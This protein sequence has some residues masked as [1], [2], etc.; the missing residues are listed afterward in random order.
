M[1][2]LL[3]SID[4]NWSLIEKNF[5]INHARHYESIF[6]LG[7]GYMTVRAIIEE[8]FE[9]DDQA[10]EYVR[11]MD[12]TTLE[13]IPAK[14]SRWGTFI[15]VFQA[16]H[17][18]LR[19]G[20]AN[21]P[22]FLNLIVEVNGEKLDLEQSIVKNHV[23]WLDLKQAVLYRTFLWE[24]INDSQLEFIYRTYMD[25][26][27]KFVSTQ[28]VSIRQLK[29]KSLIRVSGGID[30]NV[31]TNGYD[32]FTQ[33]S[34]GVS[35][36]GAI[37]SDVT[38]N[39]D[40]RVVTASV[41]NVDSPAVR[42]ENRLKRSISCSYD[43]NLEEGEVV[44][45]E[46]ISATTTTTYF[47]EVELLSTAENLINQQLRKSSE[48]RFK[49]HINAWRQKWEKSDIRIKAQD[50][51]NYNSQQAIRAAIYHLLRAKAEDEDRVMLCP[52]GS[53]TE[54]YYGSVFWDMEIFVF[55]FFLYHYPQ[56]ARTVPMFRVRN[57]PAAREIAQQYNY[58]GARYPWQSD[59]YG[60]ETCV[61]W[62]YADHQV[63]ISAD[64][65]LAIWH[66][67]RN[68][69]DKE[70]LFNYGAEVLIETARYWTERVDKIPGRPGYQ[71]L[72][73][74]GPDEYKPLTNNNAYTNRLVQ[75]NLEA[76]A[77]VIEMLIQE[78][79]D[80]FDQLGLKIGLNQHETQK[81]RK[82]AEGIS[83]PI[84]EDR[85]IIWQ[86]DDFDTAY[87]EIDIDALWKDRS[88]LFGFFV[89]QEKRYRSKCM[90]QSDVAVLLGLFSEEFSFEQKANSFDYYEPYNMQDS[91]NS[92]C[93][94]Q[95]LAAAIQRP[96]LAYEAWK[97]SIDLDFG[98]YPRDENGI[99]FANV[100]GMWQEIVFGFCGLVSSLHTD[101]LT[102][103]P[104]LPEQ[105]HEISLPL[106]WRGRKCEISLTHNNV[107][108]KNI[109]DKDLPTCVNGNRTLVPAYS[110][111]TFVVQ[112]SNTKNNLQLNSV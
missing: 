55:P 32:V 67:Y 5:D 15:P 38:T 12:N 17:P 81:F 94:H 20:I 28:E 88:Q 63:H 111:K 89:S 86:C 24:T 97:A 44:N 40:G 56:I 29:G 52:K 112:R 59:A 79:P 85:Q 45:I 95:I 1:T 8:G 71:L 109:S 27:F 19:T 33:T 107:T 110:Q 23:R 72:G 82:I 58:N 36:N 98:L 68:T 22:C 101:I 6:A 25:P 3:P 60:Q 4:P 39:L 14:K 78:A 10:F 108:I 35:P 11:M 102:L 96:Q 30:N 61:P 103:N 77:K 41:L 18:F 7:T 21:L 69:N 57:L 62:Q 70:F 26:T 105:I 46:K 99:H 90:K 2:I 54:V 47:P 91:S 87:A 31:R 84:D 66:Y 76:A 13:K 50:D 64:V 80:V 53:T 93:H 42:N 75:F 104:C 83:L 73:V 74:M 92:L 49:S 34:V 106:I 16:K 100:G 43:F 37:Y 48:M 65:S 51:E 9:D